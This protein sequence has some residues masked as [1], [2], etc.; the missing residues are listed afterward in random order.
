M[1]SQRCSIIIRISN[2]K[3]ESQVFMRE[4]TNTKRQLC[5]QAIQHD[6]LV[7]NFEFDC[8]TKETQTDMVIEETSVMKIDVG[9]QCD[10]RTQEPFHTPSTSSGTEE[11]D[12]QSSDE[13]SE[14]ENESPTDSSQKPSKAAFIVYWTSLL[15]LLERCLFPA[16]V[17]SSAVTSLI[18]KG[19]LKTILIRCVRK[20]SFFYRTSPLKKNSET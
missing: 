16:C 7:Q 19:F 18:Y 15:I 11:S 14:S 9:V 12:N 13:F 6:E 3:S 2:P 10:I 1:P 20:I 17:L 5:E 8:N 4:E